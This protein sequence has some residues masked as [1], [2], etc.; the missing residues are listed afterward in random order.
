MVTT[1]S[2][3]I[4]PLCVMTRTLVCGGSAVEDGS[5]EVVVWRV[6]CVVEGGGLV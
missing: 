4:A 1:V 5:S 6:V 3:M 2:V